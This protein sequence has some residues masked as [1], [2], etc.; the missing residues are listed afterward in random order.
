MQA[1]G[2]LG[3][4]FMILIQPVNLLAMIVSTFFG[5]LVGMLPGL[6]STMAVALLTGLSFGLPHQTALIVVISV[7]VGAISGGCQSAVLLNIPGTPASA[8]TALD[9]YPMGQQG[10]AGLAI[11]LA[12]AASFLGT[13]IS[14]VCVMFLTPVLTDL[15]L[16][17]TSPEFFLLSLF[18]IMICGSLASQGDTVK[19]WLAG[20]LGLLV[21]Q[22]GRDTM[23]S[24][25]RFSMGL[26]NLQGGIQLIPVMIGLFGFP[27]ILNMFRREDHR[28]LEMTRFSLGEGF[29]IL[30]KNV[31]NIIRSALIGVGVGVIPGV[32]EDTGGWLSYWA[33]KI[34]K[35]KEV[36]RFGKGHPSGIIASETG[37]NSCIGGAII[38]VIS[39]AV[40]GST[41]AAVLLA[42]F[43]LHGYIPGPNLMNQSPDFLY[44]ICM[45][46]FFAAVTM[47]VLATIIS[48]FSVKILGVK[49]E[50][51]MPIIFVLCVVGSFVVRSMMFDV[52]VMFV[53][54]AI[55]FL[56]FYVGL[57]AAPFLLGVILG[58]MADHKLRLTL[59][60]SGGSLA[61]F[62]TRPICIFFVIVI[63]VLACSQLGLFKWM[64]RRAKARGGKA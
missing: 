24:L 50:V 30:R 38:P 13:V 44:K 16:E 18:G 48:R 23:W 58:N 49:K 29:S 31:L 37:N 39:L 17:F 60:G 46:L 8:A 7:Y 1:L 32:G 34:E 40:P 59:Q 41:S 47:W 35:K 36:D 51:L 61:P 11:F 10:K 45:Y 14:V 55:G 64:A 57:P 3:E 56:M 6:T 15:A 25:P 12:T 5:L 4:A 26:T 28:V 43:Q 52:K 33:V 62:F 9:G 19:G 53:F 27:Q 2:F 22:I 54:G 20:L 21:A 42:A 63:V